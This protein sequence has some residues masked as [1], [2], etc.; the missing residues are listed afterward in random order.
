MTTFLGPTLNDPLGSLLFDGKRAISA[1]FNSGL[2]GFSR[3][4]TF[5][6][7]ART[8]VGASEVY[9]SDSIRAALTDNC[10]FAGI[11][12]SAY[13]NWGTLN[14][15]RRY[16]RSYSTLFIDIDGVVA[17]NE[18]PLAA[19]SGGWHRIR[20]I[21]ENVDAL[22][23]REATGRYALVFTTSRSSQ[24]RDEVDRQARA[25]GFSRFQLVMDLPHG[26]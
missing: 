13:L 8:V 14:D 2:V 23:A 18:H 11:R 19:G 24:F 17:L 26:R 22:L 5:L 10:T 7:T 6:T 12:A 1:D 4:S 25:L 21:Q 15:W 9:V 3:A 20:P 16:C